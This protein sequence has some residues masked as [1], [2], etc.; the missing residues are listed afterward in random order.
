MVAGSCATHALPIHSDRGIPAALA[1]SSNVAH[2]SGGLLTQRLR[3]R[4]AASNSL[5]CRCVSGLR[6]LLVAGIAFLS[7]CCTV[8][9]CYLLRQ[10]NY[11]ALPCLALPCHALPCRASPSP[12]VPSLARPSLS[13]SQRL[14]VN[15]PKLPRYVPNPIASPPSMS[16]FLISASLI[17]VFLKMIIR[18]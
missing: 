5:R 7:C 13:H 2:Q 3:S 17:A 1:A 6:F 11:L 18:N 8:V 16:R 9:K 15:F 4:R 14:T 10:K 12:A